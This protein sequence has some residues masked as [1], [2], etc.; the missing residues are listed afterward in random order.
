M[1]AK[2]EVQDLTE[3]VVIEQQDALATFTT[4]GALDPILDRVRKHIDVFDPDITTAAGRTRVKSM[5]Y[6]VARSKTALDVIGE[7]LA[8]EAKELPKKIDAGRKYARDTLDAWRDEVRAPL[9]KW[10]ADDKARV[11]R[12]VAGIEALKA[13][14]TTP[15]GTADQIKVQIADT[16]GVSD[17]PD[18]EEFQDGFRFAKAAALKSLREKLEWR[19][20]YDAEQAE[21]AKLRAEAEARAEA[22]RKHREAEESAK[23]DRERR[24]AIAKAAA[25]A[26]QR[27][28]EAAEKR[29][30]DEREAAER[31]EA[32]LVAQAQEAERR[33][34]EA[35]DRAR[36]KAIADAKR[37]EDEAKAAAEARER[38]R[39]HKAKVN[40]AAVDALI[41][42][43]IPE[44]H[45][46]QAVTLI[47][48]RKI[49]AVQIAY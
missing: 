10:E 1:N 33:A 36:A 40:R 32:A 17:G 14:P 48:Q 29:A 16:E 34:A 43:G 49:P 44:E 28:A 2:A 41:A 39:T 12:H 37:A 27:A 24:E 25:E 13:I 26:E 9:D 20:R 22:D 3:L 46:K 8:R 30:R 31:R 5:A 6:A 42:G 21:L 18:R 19:E 7:R 4:P 15:A 45:A 47:A 23:R 35:E 38:D 11:D